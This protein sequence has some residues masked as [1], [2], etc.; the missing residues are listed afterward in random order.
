VPATLCVE[1]GTLIED[2]VKGIDA[3]GHDV[4]IEVFSEITEFDVDN[5]PATYSPNPPVFIGSV[6]FAQLNFR[7]Q[8]DCMHVR[9]QPYQVV[10]KITDNPPKG[11][12]MVNFKI[13][14]I[15]IVAPSPKWKKAALNLVT[16][17]A[18]LEW[19]NYACANASKIQIWRKVDSFPYVPGPCDT[20]LPKFLGYNL[21]AELPTTQTTYIDTNN[22]RGLVVGAKYCYRIMAYFNSPSSTPSIVSLEECVGPI[23]ADAPVITHVSVEKTDTTQGKIR[24]SWRTPFGIN[25]AQFPKPYEYEIY[26]ANDFVG[27]T[28]IQKAG[29]VTDT[30]FVDTNLNTDAQ[31]FNYRIVLYSKPV[32]A[33]Q[34]VPVD[35]SS[36]ASSERLSFTAGVKQITLSWRDSV[37]WSNV[38]QIRPYHLIYRGVENTN[39]ANMVLLDSVDVTIDGFTYTDTELEDDKRY[40]YRVLT[41]GT[42]G[43]P[44]IAL[45][46]NFSQRITSYPINNLLPCAPSMEIKTVN[47]DEFL[48]SNNCFQNDFSNSIFWS[49][50]GLSGCRKDITA[51]KVYATSSIDGAYDVIGQVKR[52]TFYIE[53]N[54][55][56]FARCY[57]ISAV[58]M[59]GQEGPL[60]DSVCNENCPYYMLP[61]VFTPDNDGYNDVFSAN[62]DIDETSQNGI[63]IRCPRFV[64]HIDFKVYNRWGKQVYSLNTKNEEEVQINWDG[65]DSD[66][67]EVSSGVYYY[68]AE[69]NFTMLRPESRT[70]TIKGWVHIVR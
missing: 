70:R 26:R 68:N 15:K 53:N 62:F 37:P 59:L 17:N 18:E 36:V 61:N 49:L 47:C 31:V 60:S 22:G 38:A 28:N 45:Q 33:D 42:Y 14:N 43:N 65:R 39:E 54:L 50:N 66:G 10:F 67:N 30:T 56:S 19:E 44:E 35:T 32:G 25:T 27:E 57:R 24:V 51:Y 12:K 41:R 64:E 2:I 8:T 63:T 16:R 21:I 11:P 6:P 7:W 29:R 46:E 34:L 13:W 48:N 69:I 58:D 5:N 1:A 40:S 52:D 55:S 4:K 23:L 9:Q 3:D 20:G